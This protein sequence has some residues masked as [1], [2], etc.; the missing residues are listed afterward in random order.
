MKLANLFFDWESIP[1]KEIRGKYYKNV[2][3]PI[4]PYKFFDSVTLY[5]KPRRY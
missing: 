4:M 3:T 1:T 5:D 2:V